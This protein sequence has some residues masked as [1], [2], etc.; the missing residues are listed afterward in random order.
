MLGN[1]MGG[2]GVSHSDLQREMK[3]TSLRT[4]RIKTALRT[5]QTTEAATMEVEASRALL[6]RPVLVCSS[7]LQRKLRF[8]LMRYD[9]YTRRDPPYWLRMVS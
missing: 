6:C 4:T 5:A 3:L 8:Y 2:M 9:E 7:A 1:M